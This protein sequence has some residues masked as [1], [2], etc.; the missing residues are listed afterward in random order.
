MSVNF[1][2]IDPANQANQSEQTE[3]SNVA[4][5]LRRIAELAQ[6]DK[7]VDKK[8]YDQFLHTAK[9][10][11]SLR[12]QE[13][14]FQVKMQKDPG[15]KVLAELA[16][17]L[18]SLGIDLTPKNKH[19]H[20]M[21]SE[22][23]NLL[24]KLNRKEDKAEVKDHLTR[25]AVRMNQQK[26][27]QQEQSNDNHARSL[28]NSSDVKET[29]QQYSAAYAEN[30][31][32]SSPD[33]K[34]RM[35]DAQDKLKKKGFSDKEMIAMERTVKRSFRREFLSDMQDSFIQHM[36]SPKNTFEFVVSGKR[37]NNSF[38]EAIKSEQ[39]SGVSSDPQNVKDE[40]SRMGEVSREELQS[41][42][43]DAVESRLMQRHL[44]GEDNRQEVK[45]LVDLGYKVGFN[46]NT[47]LKTWEQKKFDLGLF[48]LE[49][50]E[51]D[52]PDAQGQ[53]KIGEV[54][55]GEVGDKHGYEMTKDEEKEL[56]INQL[57]AEYMKKALTGDPFAVFSFAPKIRKLQ[58]GM[59]KLG[60]ESDIFN[61]IEQEGKVL[62]RFRTLEMLKE[63]MI[64]R[65][66]YY[67]LS[68]P[69]YNLLKNKI[70][71]YMSNMDRL[72]MPL[73]K[74]QVEMLTDDANRA[75]YDHTIIEIKSA[76][77]ILENSDNPA[78]EQKV[79][80]M[81]KLIQRLREESGFQHGLGEDLE[82]AVFTQTS[83]EKNV[84]EN[85]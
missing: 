27:E 8:A 44:S 69:A 25:D 17:D 5:E 75:M 60:L 68:G 53:L 49:V 39:L 32:A 7:Q 30:V 20:K 70:K 47:F 18:S 80:L 15:T 74:D 63:A 28:I 73:G 1:N 2:Q 45:K 42:V 22:F 67:E 21:E 66:T 26:K 40:M 38:N 77:A 72:G 57:R 79:P 82:S 84:K 58:N 59:I 14:S 12:Q 19:S 55:A 65:S 13:R 4:S 48:I 64:E 62:A 33:A 6:T 3:Q 51:V 50:Q 85:A 76:E 43:R 16:R 23:D 34:N 36:F 52:R 11:E 31:L 46:F 54:N 83:D 61:R 24:E 78:L 35:D 71:G 81:A 56:L 10:T 9:R 29:M 41:F 37:L